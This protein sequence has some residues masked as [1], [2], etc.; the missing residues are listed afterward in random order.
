[1]SFLDI[2]RR[3]GQPAPLSTRPTDAFANEVLLELKSA[4]SLAVREAVEEVEGRF[5]RSV[6][7]ESFFSLEAFNVRPCDRD[8]ARRFDEFLATHES[9]DPG[10]RQSFFRQVLEPEYRSSRG[11]VVRVPDEFSV[12]VELDADALEPMTPEESFQVSLKGRRVMFRASARLAGPF[13]R[14]AQSPR[15]PA[16][17]PERSTAGAGQPVAPASA[18]EGGTRLSLQILD[19]AGSRTLE[20]GLP[21]LIGR[22]AE[23]MAQR[24][25]MTGVR[26]EATYVSRQHLVFFELMGSVRYTLADSASLACVRAGDGV[27]LAQGHHYRLSPAERL[28]LH[29]GVALDENSATLP[30]GEVGDHPVVQVSLAGPSAGTHPG[31]PRPRAAR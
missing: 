18:A 21:V 29:F 27:V 15:A 6:L 7:Q 1:M 14:P 12:S 26:L 3:G 9:V 16:P 17:S 23:A 5:M 31:T 28:V 25:A 19:G 2:F 11:S 8:V 30:L 10:F 22:E 13:R 24:H 4:A 20:V